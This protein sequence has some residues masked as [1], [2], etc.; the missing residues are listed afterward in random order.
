MRSPRSS[1]R[2]R[3]CARRVAIELHPALGDALLAIDGRRRAARTGWLVQSVHVYAG[4]HSPGAVVRR[5][6]IS[7]NRLFTYAIRTSDESG[8]SPERVEGNVYLTNGEGEV[9]RRVRGRA[10]SAAG[11]E[12]A[13][14]RR[15]SIRAAGCIGLVGSRSHSL[16]ASATTSATQG[17]WLI[18]AD[19]RGVGRD[20][21]DQLAARGQA[22]ILVEPGKEFKFQ[23]AAVGQ[24]QARSPRDSFGQSA[25]RSPLSSSS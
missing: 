6:K 2:N 18:L 23:S 19:Q 22:S 15:R 24:R 25:R 3:S 21:A 5:L 8:P 9:L 4:W 7:R 10:S 1:C 20:L 16:A 11:A 17:A 12:R 14:R 13:G